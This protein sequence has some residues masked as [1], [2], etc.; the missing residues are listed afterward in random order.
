MLA[1]T[2][3]D[4]LKY[5]EKYLTPLQDRFDSQ[6]V[7]EQYATLLNW[8]LFPEHALSPVVSASILLL[9]MRCEAL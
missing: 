5:P 9:D 2:I 7:A 4:A 3:D 1:A 6:R 8:L